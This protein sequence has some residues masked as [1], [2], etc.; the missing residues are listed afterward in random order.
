MS[1][2]DTYTRIKR[3]QKIANISVGNRFPEIEPDISIKT[4][5]QNV[6]QQMEEIDKRDNPNPVPNIIN[7]SQ[8]KTF[9]FEDA[10]KELQSM[11]RQDK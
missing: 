8:I 6:F 10:L 9:S 4:L 11:A 1:L 5:T 7:S 2:E 3:G